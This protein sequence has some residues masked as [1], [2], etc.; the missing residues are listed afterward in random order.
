M[1]YVFC[2]VLVAGLIP[3]IFWLITFRKLEA[4][5]VAMDVLRGETANTLAAKDAEVL[6]CIEESKRQQKEHAEELARVHAQMDEYTHNETKRIGDHYAAEAQRI[7][8]EAYASV[9]TLIDQLEP[10]RKFQG[11]AD[12]E[13]QTRAVLEQA[14]TEANAL[15]QDAEV[16]LAHVRDQ[17]NAE[18]AAMAEEMARNR[19]QV[20]ALLAQGRKDAAR[21]IEEA[22]ERAEQVAG[23]AFRA[24]EERDQ[25][26]STLASLR[27]QIEGYVDQSL[28]PSRSVLDDVA[29]GFGAEAA[30]AR[31]Q[32]ARQVTEQMVEAGEAATCDYVEE[33]RKNQA[34]RFVTDA[35]N[36]RV[37]SI[38]GRAKADNQANLEQD[39]R[40]AYD[41]VNLNGKAFRDARI[42]EHYL[43]A[44]LEEL[45]WACALQK[46]LQQRREEER[47]RREKLRDEEMA[48]REIDRMMKEAAKEEELKRQAYEEAE[49][50]LAAATAEEREERERELAALRQQL[51]DSTQRKLTVAQLRKM[52][53]VYVISNEGSFGKGVLKVG[54][55]RRP[56]PRERVGELSDASVPFPFDIHGLIKCENAPVLEHLVHR[57]LLSV[58]VNKMNSRKEFFRIDVAELK[59]YLEQL[60]EKFEFTV[61]S[62]EEEVPASDYRETLAIEQDPSKR[63]EWL[64]RMRA[65]ADDDLRKD[66][67][68]MN[69][70]AKAEAQNVNAGEPDSQAVTVPDARPVT[71]Q[72]ES[73]QTTL[74]NATVSTP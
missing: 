11:L 38:L 9:Q 7:Y 62:W 36:G 26:N 3:A 40:G 61:E 37:D 5:R 20:V 8:Q 57:Q 41:A 32:A 73:A 66:E 72:D 65:K 25:L 48:R 27:R 23:D 52:G 56:D 70:L 60:R 18:K 47:D 51:V 49:E 44:R 31:Y 67:I 30:A 10:L 39:V 16:A 68:R 54:H 55:T 13:A 1:M 12:A 50:R 35:F 14:I 29:V 24:L 2:G 43:E 4:A 53:Y 74:S 22:K 59:T 58:Q 33:Y 34:M 19:D 46:L 17:C 69:A 71:E 64:G 28:K 63:E 21:L 45:R 6:R 42:R 15:K